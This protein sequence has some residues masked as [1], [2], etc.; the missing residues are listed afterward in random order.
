MITPEKAELIGFLCSEGCYYKYIAKYW[1]FDKRRNN[2]YFRIQEQEV[3]QMGNN[4]PKIQ[5]RFLFLLEKIYKYKIK[6][7]GNPHSMRCTIKRKDV[8][9]DLIKYSKT[10]NSFEWKLHKTICNGS[11]GVKLGFLRG[12]FDGDGS[13]SKT[14]KN[15]YKIRIFS[16]NIKE[17]KKIQ[18]ILNS[19]S[20]KSKIYGP[21]IGGRG[22]TGIYE[23]TLISENAISFVNKV[24]PTK[25]IPDDGSKNKMVFGRKTL[26]FNTLQQ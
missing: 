25:I 2:S 24:K 7:Y 17:L 8:I 18:K 12:Y 19:L 16:V 15:R 10:Y 5:N 13:I 6:F 14:S 20:M 11:P 9:H 1:S 22:K 23:L 26:V 4:N 21:Y 3:L